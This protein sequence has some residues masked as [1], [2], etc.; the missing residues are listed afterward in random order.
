MDLQLFTQKISAHFKNELPF[1]L[2]S[3]PQENT[4]TALIQQSSVLYK[5]DEFSAN[6]FIFAPFKFEGE[7]FFIPESDSEKITCEFTKTSFQME[8][9]AIAEN[10]VE[11][12]EYIALVEK[13]IEHIKKRKAKKIVASRSKDLNLDHFS[14]D[15]LLTRLFSAYPSAFCYI[16]YHPETGFWCGATPETL[17]QITN[18][19]FKTM[20]L[21]GTQPYTANEVSWGP[22]ELDE[23][24]LVTDA[25]TTNL[26]RVTSLLKVSNPYTYQAGPLLHL[27]TDI[28]G[29]LRSRKTTLT[30]IAAAVHPTPAVCGVPQKY[31]KQFI[32]EN[33]GYDR[34]FY[35]GFL[36]PIQENGNRAM[37]MVNLRCMKI[38]NNTAH[39]FVGGG[40]TIGSKPMDEWQ[41]TQNKL[42]TMLQVL[43]PML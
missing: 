1:V 16:W 15:T 18:D 30:K 27:K 42:Q 33:E 40:I 6:G 41:E 3:L 31:A 4:I 25:I 12:Y 19:T 21:A 11:K 37:L 43:S 22:K 35:T 9:V 28:S 23:Q 7:A 34:T 13:I 39:I 29:V 14:I 32:I 17:V 2:F 38:D 26:Q 10:D 36:G 24:Q 8:P 20:A 5:S